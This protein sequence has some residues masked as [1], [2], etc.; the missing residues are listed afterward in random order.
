MNYL[1]QIFSFVRSVAFL[2]SVMAK[3]KKKMA[4]NVL[5]EQL[6][7]EPILMQTF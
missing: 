7:P 5:K 4:M 6:S 2:V 1:T 3:K